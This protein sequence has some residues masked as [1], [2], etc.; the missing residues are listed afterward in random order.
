[1]KKALKHIES[2]R[3]LRMEGRRDLFGRMKSVGVKSLRRWAA[4][5][6]RARANFLRSMACL[7]PI[8]LFW[9]ADIPVDPDQAPGCSDYGD[10]YCWNSTPDGCDYF[11]LVAIYPDDLRFRG[12]KCINGLLEGK[13]TIKRDSDYMTIERGAMVDGKREGR[14]HSLVFEIRGSKEENGPEYGLIDTYQYADFANG[15]REGPMESIHAFEGDGPFIVKGSFS[16][17]IANGTWEGGPVLGDPYVRY[18]FG[19][20]AMWTEDLDSETGEWERTGTLRKT[21]DGQLV[22]E[23][24]SPGC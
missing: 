22:D 10:V 20:D 4:K 18:H 8:L 13:G 23:T 6:R 12:F 24:G 21:E 2:G 9:L 7:N 19:K 15:V 5:A 11:A 17:G 1:M 14:W 3:P 16:N